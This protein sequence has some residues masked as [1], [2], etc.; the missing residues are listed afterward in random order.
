M[1]DLIEVKENDNHYFVKAI[2]DDLATGQ[3]EKFI[4]NFLDRTKTFFMHVKNFFYYM[5]F[6]IL[7]CI[8]L[9]ILICIILRR[10]WYKIM[11]KVRKNKI[12]IKAKKPTSDDEM[13]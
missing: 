8:I 9:I 4:N 7:T 10:N 1:S 13:E 2:A 12:K 6:I 3:A 11:Y 5:I